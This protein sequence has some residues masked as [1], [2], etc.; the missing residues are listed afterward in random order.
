MKKPRTSVK[1]HCTKCIREL[2]TYSLMFILTLIRPTLQRKQPA[3]LPLFYGT[4]NEIHVRISER[5]LSFSKHSATIIMKLN[6][7]ENSHHIP[8]SSKRRVPLFPG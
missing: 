2:P 8:T 3:Q 5:A 7:M 4:V 6:I 1:L